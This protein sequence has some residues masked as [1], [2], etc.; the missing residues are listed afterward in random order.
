MTQPTHAHEASELDQARALF[1][2]IHDA[3]HEML[4]KIEAGDPTRAKEAAMRLAQVQE[5][6]L[7][8]A[9]LKE[10]F[11]DKHGPR[12]GEFD[13]AAARAAIGCKLD[14]LR[15]CCDAGRLSCEL[16]RG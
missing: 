13:L 2:S 16:E 9:K 11:D 15:A 12:E 3:L 8:V 10:Q 5:A 4:F 14:R 1:H 6:A 7:R